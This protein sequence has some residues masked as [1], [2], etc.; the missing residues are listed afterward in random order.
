MDVMMFST[1]GD[2]SLCM[3]NT[4]TISPMLME[5]IQESLALAFPR[6]TIRDD[7]AASHS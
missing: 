7:G 4:H 5:G 2:R 1:H 6:A 3:H